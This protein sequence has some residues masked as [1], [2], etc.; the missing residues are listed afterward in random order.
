MVKKYLFIETFYEYQNNL[1]PVYN[2]SKNTHVTLL[3][4]FARSTC[5]SYIQFLSDAQNIVYYKDMPLNKVCKLRL[6]HCIL[7][8]FVGLLF[9][10]NIRIAVKK[11]YNHNN[12]AEQIRLHNHFLIRV[13]QSRTNRP[14]YDNFHVSKNIFQ[15]HN[16]VQPLAGQ[17]SC[18]VTVLKAL[19]VPV[20]FENN[21]Q[22]R[23]YMPQFCFLS[24][25]LARAKIVQTPKQLLRIVCDNIIPCHSNIAAA[26]PESFR[27]QASSGIFSDFGQD[28]R[29]LFFYDRLRYP[30]IRCCHAEVSLHELPQSIDIFRYF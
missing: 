8:L 10:H 26:D 9:Y 12:Q 17:S 3:K 1:L 21:S 27:L 20:P 24:I 6:F 11:E 29:H 25:H 18:C 30:N 4:S 13:E 14:Q 15:S 22:H 19:H 28:S 7:S 5:L 16:T 2:S 23:P